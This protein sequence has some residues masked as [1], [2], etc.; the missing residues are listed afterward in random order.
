MR[1]HSLVDDQFREA[2]GRAQ[3]SHIVDLRIAPRFDVGH[4]NRRAA[5]L[6]F[7][8]VGAAYVDLGGQPSGWDARQVGPTLEA[9]LS[10]L[11]AGRSIVFLFSTNAGSLLR[12]SEVV[13]ALACFEQET[14]AIPVNPAV[15]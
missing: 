10:S 9:I 12:P 7:D 2:I 14:P 8:E 5:F 3:P 15:S 6:F 13:A 1:V 11:D 4:L